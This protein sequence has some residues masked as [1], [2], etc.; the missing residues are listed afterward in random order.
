MQGD[1]RDLLA[2]LARERISGNSSRLW[3][4]PV[5]VCQSGATLML[6]LLTPLL[7]SGWRFEIWGAN[8][9]CV[10]V[11][12]AFRG[13]SLL[14]RQTFELIWFEWA[15]QHRTGPDLINNLSTL[16]FRNFLLQF[17]RIL[18]WAHQG[19]I[20]DHFCRCS[21]I[22]QHEILVNLHLHEGLLD[23]YWLQNVHTNRLWKEFIQKFEG[24]L[25]ALF[26]I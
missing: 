21:K 8:K 20:F 2:R 14:S 6:R 1:A 22:S 23:W 11:V 26:E 24:N 9:V 18:I 17:P 15:C 13:I 12:F 10:A 5:L 16:R 19:Q 3:I 7:R 4:S 25:F